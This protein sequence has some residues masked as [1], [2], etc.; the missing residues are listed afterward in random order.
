MTK[1]SLSKKHNKSFQSRHL[2]VKNCVCLS[3]ITNEK[4][5]ITVLGQLKCIHEIKKKK[6]FK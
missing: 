4:A 2:K 6:F 1:N 5:L 3:V